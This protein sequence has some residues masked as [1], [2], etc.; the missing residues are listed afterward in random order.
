MFNDNKNDWHHQ[1][2]HKKLHVRFLNSFFYF[3]NP[4]STQF[5]LC[6]FGSIFTYKTKITRKLFEE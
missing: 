6:N 5:L 3:S 1:K 4:A 2:K